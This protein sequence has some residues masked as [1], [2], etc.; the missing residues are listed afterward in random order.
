[1]AKKEKAVAKTAAE[2]K[3]ETAAAMEAQNR[4]EQAAEKAKAAAAMEA[5]N[6]KKQ[7]AAKA[8]ADEAAAKVVTA[9]QKVRDDEKKR[10]LT[11]DERMR[12]NFLEELA[13]CKG[14]SPFPTEMLELG[15]LR[16]RAKLDEEKTE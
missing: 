11:V 1:M 5:E 2:S 6:K 9:A 14:R 12:L 4:K 8:K 13:K 15:R 16:A 3:A 7:A 10:P